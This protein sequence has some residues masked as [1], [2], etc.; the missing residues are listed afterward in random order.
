MLGPRNETNA[1]FTEELYFML[2]VTLSIKSLV[3]IS[4]NGFNPKTLN[5]EIG[6][7]LNRHIINASISL[8]SS[9]TSLPIS[10]SSNS[11]TPILW[12]I[13]NLC[14]AFPLI[15]SSFQSLNLSGSWIFLF[16]LPG[17]TII[18][19]RS[20]PFFCSTFLMSVSCS[21]LLL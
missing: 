10:L 15:S 11:S 4:Q 12:C 8:S 5:K 17:S 13:A 21:C 16:G 9:F 6:N 2:L 19:F 18:P 3:S 14:F 7:H 1:I 20:W